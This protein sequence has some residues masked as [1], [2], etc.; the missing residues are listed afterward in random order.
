MS[1]TVFDFEPSS[2]L[3]AEEDGLY[4]YRRLAERL[5]PLM[6][7]RAL[8]G[9]E[10]GYQQGEIVQQFLQKAFPEAN[11]DIVQDINKKDRMIFCEIQ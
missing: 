1:A 4:F 3:F 2:A 11:V 10:I 8:I 5:A 7:K 9:F 6:N